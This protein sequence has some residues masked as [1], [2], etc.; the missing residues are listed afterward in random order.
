MG[1]KTDKLLIE[2]SKEAFLMAIEI[3]NKPTIKYRVE[4]FSF[5]I[6]N[7]WELMLKAYLIRENG[8]PSI[9]Y[10]NGRTLSL[11]AC[12]NK[13]FTN[14]ND[15]LRKNLKSIMNLRNTATHFITEDYEQIYAPLFQANIINFVN[16][17]SQLL[18][19]DVTEKIDQHFLSLSV[20]VDHLDDN[21]VKSKYSP[22]IA[23]Q[24]LKQKKK[25]A[26]NAEA[27]GSSTAYLIPIDHNIYITKNKK[28]ADFIVSVAEK[29][30]NQVQII[31]QLRDPKNTHPFTYKKVVEHVCNTLEAKKISP[32]YNNKEVKFNTYYL[33][34]FI[35]F[36]DVKSDVKYAYNINYGHNKSLYTYSQ[37]F[38]E[39]ITTKLINNPKKELDQLKKAIKNE[40]A[41]GAKE[42]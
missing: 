30:D 11:E 41:P 3:Y 1:K 31:Q 29:N 4:G 26:N 38:I 12:L 17:A 39:F 36:Y 23:K 5:F 22:Y 25:I 40:L 2:K 28:D 8:E 15:P 7:A 21:V 42:F 32:M 34:L 10:K 33:S 19:I 37:S 16:K 20:N 9:Y 24:I 35:R 14:S 6:C 27:E 18:G 13:V